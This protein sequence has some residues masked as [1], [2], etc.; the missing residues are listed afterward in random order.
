MEQSSDVLERLVTCCLVDG[1]A[2]VEG[3]TAEAISRALECCSDVRVS[4]LWDPAIR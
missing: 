2:A 4:R 3:L 1:Q